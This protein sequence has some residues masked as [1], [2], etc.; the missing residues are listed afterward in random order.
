MSDKRNNLVWGG[1]LILLG[2]LLM[3]D[4]LSLIPEIS[5]PVWAVIMGAS[6]LF[7]IGVYLYTGKRHWGWLFPIFITG[8]LGITAVLTLTEFNELWVGALFMA[9]ISAPFW[10]IFLLN[11]KENWWALIPGWVTAV[12]ALIILVSEVWSGEIIGAL[13]MWSISL[14]F[15]VVYLRNRSYWWALIPGFIMAGMGLVVL[16]STENLGEIMGTFVM[17]VMALPFFGVFFFTKG[18]WWAII[19]AGILTTIALIIP[20][21]ANVEDN[22]FGGRL[23]AFVMFLGFSVPFIWLWFQR[24]IYPTSWA[25]YPSVGF[26]AAAFVT[27]ALGAVM[28]T[29]WPILLIVI[30]A[31]LLLDNFRQPKLKP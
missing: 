13:V 5:Q 1:V 31:W 24:K 19:P 21:A 4:S 2:A 7:F 12:L 17:L 18:Q 11:R 10:I 9:F 15:I 23:V 6:C 3:L 28:E 30:G 22:S 14:P 20:F 27:L 26:I 25:K 8:G 16:L 29:S